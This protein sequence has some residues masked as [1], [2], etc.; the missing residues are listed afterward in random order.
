[1]TSEPMTMARHATRMRDRI[2]ESMKGD[3]D[4]ERTY[5]FTAAQT[6][7]LTRGT[8]YVWCFRSRV[9]AMCAGAFV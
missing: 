4:V 6:R 5:W 3:M 7:D 2:E 9:Y 1:M 8:L